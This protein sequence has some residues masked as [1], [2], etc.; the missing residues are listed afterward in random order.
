MCKHLCNAI[1]K[2]G[3]DQFEVL[4]EC[5]E[6]VA[7]F[8]ESHFMSEFNTLDP[9]HGYNLICAS[10]RTKYDRKCES[11]LENLQKMVDSRRVKKYVDMTGEERSILATRLKHLIVQYPP[12]HN[13]KDKGLPKYVRSFRCQRGYPGYKVQIQGYPVKTY[14]SGFTRS[15]Q[16]ALKE[17]L[18]YLEICMTKANDDKMT[19]PETTKDGSESI[20]NSK[21]T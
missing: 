6:E 4:L 19:F 21:K 2:Y 8:Y 18:D 9:N 17:A 10:H 20:A 13:G 14:R 3:G 15:T 16:H 1:N 5:K 12:G 7:V 11:F